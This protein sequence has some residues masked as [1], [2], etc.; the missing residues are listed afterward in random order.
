MD[1]LK[2][3]REE[4]INFEGFMRIR[5]AFSN[6]SGPGSRGSFLNYNNFLYGTLC[7]EKYLFTEATS[8]T[9]WLTV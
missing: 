9:S 7:T 1:A 5:K 6:K 3:K 4:K 8:S 2:S